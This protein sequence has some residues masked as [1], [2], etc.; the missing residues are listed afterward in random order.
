MRMKRAIKW[1]A[2]ALVLACCAAFFANSYLAGRYSVRGADLSHYQGVVD[3]AALE[4]QGLSFVFIKA[5][6]G[7]AHTDERFEE[8]LEKV[9]KTSLR[10]GFYHFF[11]FDSPGKTQAENFIARVP[12]LDGMLPPV[13][14]VEYYG[15]YFRNPPDAA[16]VRPE[17]EA[18]IDALTAH[19]GVK[20]ILYST[21]RAYERYLKGAFEDC[22]LWIRSVY[23]P[24]VGVKWTFWQYT[25]RARLNGYSGEESRIDLNVFSGNEEAFSR[26][27][28]R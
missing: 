23:F 14:D 7:S 11:S 17:L 10:Y 6:E 2:L 1:I 20:P 15:D 5:T 27:G 21:L 12:Q 24:P 16:R 3:F 26:Y 19:Y 13:I 4:A 8:N 28:L 9:R 22:D 18:M 25:D